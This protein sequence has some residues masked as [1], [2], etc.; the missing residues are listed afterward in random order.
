SAHVDF[1]YLGCRIQ[2]LYPL[3]YRTGREIWLRRNPGAF[4]GDREIKRST[5]LS[6]P[7]CTI[8]AQ[9]RIMTMLHARWIIQRYTDRGIPD[10]PDLK[11]I[12]GTRIDRSPLRGD[13]HMIDTI[14]GFCQTVQTCSIIVVG[15]KDTL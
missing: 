2:P 11:A 6:A 15:K 4:T 5:T 14:T 9:F 12:P 8:A 3:I 1:L 10:R 7:V 13:L